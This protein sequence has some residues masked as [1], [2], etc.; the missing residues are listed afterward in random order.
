LLPT[1]YSILPGHSKDKKKTPGLQFC[2]SEGIVL[3]HQEEQLPFFDHSGQTLP[4]SYHTL[5][6]EVLFLQGKVE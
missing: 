2:R 3:T 1:V 6:K 4:D 5:K